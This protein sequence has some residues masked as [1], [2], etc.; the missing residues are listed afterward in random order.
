MATFATAGG[1]AVGGKAI[2]R[3]EIAGFEAVEV[4]LSRF[5]EYLHDLREFWREYFAPAFYRQ[6]ER[7]Y[8]TAGSM[9]GGWAPLSPRYAAWKAVVAPGRSLL[10]F[11]GRLQKSVTWQGDRPGEGGIFVP[12]R[13][14]VVLGTS[15]PYARFHQIG[16]DRMPRRSILFPGNNASSTFGRLMHRYAVDMAGEAGLRA[17]SARASATF[18]GQFL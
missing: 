18:G 2:L 16:T 1:G 15:V 4:R 12:E 5:Q 14:Y 3:L 9:V 11:T 8:E 17:A 7:N 10:Q 6:I 13:T